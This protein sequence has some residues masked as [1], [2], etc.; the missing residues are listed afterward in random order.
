MENKELIQEA[1][2]IMLD[3]LKEMSESKKDDFYDIGD[4]IV[5]CEAMMKMAN[6]IAMISIK[7]IQ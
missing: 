4:Y 1:Q 7:S 2:K 3:K 6:V 5:L